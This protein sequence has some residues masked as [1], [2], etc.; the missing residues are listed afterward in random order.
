MGDRKQPIIISTQILLPCILLQIG[1]KFRIVCALFF[2]GSHVKRLSGYT[3]LCSHCWLAKQDNNSCSLNLNI[4]HWL[5]QM[6]NLQRSGCESWHILSKMV[7]KS[8]TLFSQK[9]YSVKKLKFE[10]LT[11]GGS[12]KYQASHMVTYC[13]FVRERSQ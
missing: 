6:W 12:K 7:L 1:F 4:T 9:L 8:K 11:F 2:G 13:C 5:N 10:A 3:F